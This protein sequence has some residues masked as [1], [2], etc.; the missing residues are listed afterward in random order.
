MLDPEVVEGLTAVINETYT[1]E[2][3]FPLAGEI[4]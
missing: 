4:N 2:I 3:E 1:D